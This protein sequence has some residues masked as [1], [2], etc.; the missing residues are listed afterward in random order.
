MLE[1]GSCLIWCKHGTLTLLAVTNWGNVIRFH[2]Y[3]PFIKSR[4]F[5]MSANPENDMQDT[6]WSGVREVLRMSGPIVLGSSSYAIMGF[7]DCFMVARLGSDALAS[8]GSAR[9][10]SFIF[11]TFFLGMVGC[12]STFV[13]QSLGRGEKMN[14]AKYAW[15]GIYVSMMAGTATLVF[16]PLSAPLFGLMNHTDT[17]TVLEI[18]YFRIRLLGYVF[19]AWQA[20]LAGFFQAV[21]RPMIPMAASF[22][23]NALNIFLDYVLIYGKLGF[24]RWGVEG[25]AAATVVALLFQVCLLQM[26]FMNRRT[27]RDFGSRTAFAFDYSKFR[28]LLRI[29]WPAGLSFFFGLANWGIFNAFIV[30]HFGTVSL[31]ANTATV[32]VLHVSLMPAIGLNHGI[33]PI[34]GNWIGRG[35]IAMAKSRAYTA[36]KLAMVY[37]S[38]MGVI[39][40]LFGG[41]IMLFFSEDPQVIALGTKLMIL[42]GIFQ[43]FDAI[44]VVCSGALRGA[45]DTRF[46]AIITICGDYF[47]FL[48]LALL[49]AF[50]ANMAA[51]GAW[52][53]VT[54]FIITLSGAMFWRLSGERW[55]KINIFAEA[56]KISQGDA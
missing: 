43:L 31:A 14:C 45:G 23:A 34:V 56:D 28:E 12:V 40:V 19:I 41:Q 24:P 15:Q 38:S 16:W 7:A 47:F 17:V 35:N 18:G 42:A 39:F 1:C 22:A 36:I 5:S 29:G 37:M 30:G 44:N 13:S 3:S 9:V 21:K 49:L 54:I 48:P 51:V 26:I 2:D 53:G 11:G 46:L 27:N 4:K 6:R 33:A 10:W 50:V 32:T 55:A 8:L 25:A 52:I 20:A